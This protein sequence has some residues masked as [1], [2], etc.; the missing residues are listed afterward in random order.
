[1][2]AT[3]MAATAVRQMHCASAAVLVTVPEEN[4]HMPWCLY[5][6]WTSLL[7]LLLLDVLALS[8]FV[9]CCALVC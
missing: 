7:Q 2:L 5:S 6:L 8:S 1:M 3:D 9:R 4:K